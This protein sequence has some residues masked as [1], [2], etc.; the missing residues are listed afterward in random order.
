MTT[1][2]LDVIVKMTCIKYGCTVTLSIMSLSHGKKGLIMDADRANIVSGY[3]QRKISLWSL[4]F[5]SAIELFGVLRVSPPSSNALLMPSTITNFS[6]REHMRWH[7]CDH[8]WA[9]VALCSVMNSVL[10]HTRSIPLSAKGSRA[11]KH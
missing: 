11:R 7:L 1:F 10:F 6:S 4:D 8:S 2:L 9:M 5:C 3:S